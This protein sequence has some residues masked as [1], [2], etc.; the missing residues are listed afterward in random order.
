MEVKLVFNLYP[1]SDQV[2]LPSANV[3][4]V[5]LDGQLAHVLQRATRI[6]LESYP[7]SPSEEEFQLLDLIERLQP[8]NIEQHFKPTRAKKVSSLAV[9]LTDKDTRKSVMGYI[10]RHLADFLGKVYRH[11]FPL[12]LNVEKKMLAKDVLLL[13]PEGDL[14]PY[15]HFRKTGESMEYRLRLGTE[16]EK[17][18]V[19][20]HDVAPM[21][22]T[23]PAWILVN[24]MLFRVPGINGNMVNPF[25]TKDHIPIP[26]DKVHT[27]F[28]TFI[29]KAL[30]RCEIEAEGFDIVQNT[31]IR[32]AR[33]VLTE[34]VLEGNWVFRLRF[35]YDG[36]HFFAG[37]TRDNVTSIEISESGDDVR[38]HKLVRDKIGEG[39]YIQE[40]IVL[41]LEFDNRYFNPSEAEMDLQ[42]GISWL[43]QHRQALK[44]AG[45][46]IESPEVE[47]RKLSVVESAIKLDSQESG[48][49]FDVEGKVQIGT[50][51]FSF[52]Q[53]VPNLRSQNPYFEL[54]DG[55]WFLI[56]EAWFTR[57]SELAGVL[58][59]GTNG[60]DLRIRKSLFTVVEGAGIEA[61]EEGF[62]IIDPELVEYTPGRELKAT[63][64]PYQLAGVKWLVGHYQHGFGACL[65][66]DMGLGKTL[67]T[68]AALLHIKSSKVNPDTGDS[69]SSTAQLDLFSAHEESIQ[70]LRA[71]I[72]LPSSLVFNWQ[73][74]IQK[75]APSLFCYAHVGPKR[76]KDSRAMA[77][78]DV[79]LTTYQTARKDLEIIEKVHWTAIVLDES[80]QIKNRDSGVSKV[81]RSLEGDFRLSLSG[82]P[83]ENS[84]SDLWTQMDFINPA[85]LGSYSSFRELFQQPIEKGGSAD[86]RERLQKR[87]HPF[88]MRRTKEEVAPDLPELSEQVFYSEMAAEQK[89]QYDRVKSA[90]RN[91]I[92]ALFDD[93]GTRMQ[94]L[95]ALM[96]LRQISNHPALADPD[97]EGGSGKFEDV[98]AFWD[99]VKRSGHK[100]LFF[101]SFEKHLRLFREHFETTRQPY[102]WLTGETPAAQ[103]AGEV[104]RFQED[105]HVQA[106]FMTLK[107]GGVGL[108]LTA[109]DYVFILDP[110]WNPAIEAQAVARAHRIGQVHP[111]TAIR[112]LS[113][114]SIEEKIAVLQEKKRALGESLF[115][116]KT[117][118]PGLGRNDLE[119]I[120][121]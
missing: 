20:D 53:F 120:L 104:Q 68:I 94:A 57:Y 65:A 80:Q 101:S 88:F 61:G 27:Y 82:T 22:N 40:L 32:K 30:Q 107:A 9:L 3:I 110:W 49:W 73:R 78:H 90:M 106:F 69:E 60:T 75:F 39:K 54:P 33:L 18:K 44:T 28:K 15:L 13:Y 19:S 23:D 84:L 121:S 43:V 105:Q 58:E 99:Q 12:T 59:D 81:V 10:H 89:K 86:A 87:V 48:D 7:V 17:W 64:R 96:Q 67:Q 98:L 51:E 70:P 4:S 76:V 85:T 77:A 29:A 108:N 41:G 91:K 83:I 92:L 34:N 72:I 42:A 118:S 45:I 62:P 71:L 16:Q 114:E 97:Y 36:Q 55:S 66:D 116:E 31:E 93:P 115:E 74:E 119:L 109:A 38:V 46:S 50:F 56:P 37:E 52:K 95:Q 103:R 5:D 6:T 111:V 26:P 24:Y 117:Q 112:F 102:A 1:I 25:R 47:G 79:V 2:F 14:I 100:A 63:L 113:R 21:T 35:D 8:G 11:K